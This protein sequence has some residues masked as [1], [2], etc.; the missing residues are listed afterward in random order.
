MAHSDAISCFRLQKLSQLPLNSAKRL[1]QHSP[2]VT[3]RHAA[4]IRCGGI[5]SLCIRSPES[6]RIVARTTYCIRIQHYRSIGTYVRVRYI[7]YT[8]SGENHSSMILDGV[9]YPVIHFFRVISSRMVEPSCSQSSLDEYC[10]FWSFTRRLCL[11]LQGY[12]IVRSPYHVSKTLSP[13]LWRGCFSTLVSLTS[14]LP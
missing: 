6:D 11:P 4:C 9:C 12:A 8:E 2:R 14:R 5:L 10:I 1:V 7:G 3:I 13:S